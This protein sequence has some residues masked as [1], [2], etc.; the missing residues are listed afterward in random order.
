MFKTL[1][2]IFET[3]AQITA[4]LDAEDAAKKAD[5]GLWDDELGCWMGLPGSAD[6]FNWMM[7]DQ[8]RQDREDARIAAIIAA[9]QI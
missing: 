1:K 5:R 8:D 3:D 7:L 2:A 4:R 6:R 9:R